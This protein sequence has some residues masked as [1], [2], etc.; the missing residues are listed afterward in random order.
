MNARFAVR[1]RALVG[2]E[3]AHRRML[4]LAIAAL[5]VL[6]VG[7]IFGH[8]FATQIEHGLHG[9]DHLGALCLIALHELVE[10]F[11]RLFHVLIAAGL[12]Y[13]LYDRARAFWRTRGVLASLPTRPARPGDAFSTAAAAVGVDPARLRVAGELPNPAFTIGWIRP[14]IYLAGSLA[15][16]L[17]P[18]E[19]EALLAHEGAHVSRRDPL[20]LSALRFLA[21]LLFWIPALRRLAADVADEAEIQADDVAAGARPLALASALLTLARQPSAG[22]DLPDVVGFSHAAKLLDRRIR[23]LAGESPVPETRVTR[24][25]IAGA[26]LALSM[27]TLSG[28]VMVHPLPL[29]GVGHTLTHCDHEHEHAV[30]HLFCFPASARLDGAPCPHGRHPG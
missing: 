15:S 4:L 3:E 11:H 7:P 8:H 16:R 28:V 22:T 24:R 20:R 12:A 19:L 30:S 23:R 18:A 6:S 10:P 9:Q 26:L 25:S 21:L 13:A 14:R 27:V 17:S 2:K 5:L 1:R 29:D